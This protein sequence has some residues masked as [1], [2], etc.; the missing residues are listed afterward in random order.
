MT[1][2]PAESW[3]FTVIKSNLVVHT[4]PQLI[5]RNRRNI[6]IKNLALKHRDKITGVP[7]VNRGL[8]RSLWAARGLP[9]GRIGK[10]GR[11]WYKATLYASWGGS[12]ASL[13]ARTEL[14][15]PAHV[16]GHP[17]GP[18]PAALPAAPD[19]TTPLLESSEA[20]TLLCRVNKALW[21]LTAR[22][23]VRCRKYQSE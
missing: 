1:S 19:S 14:S 23:R 11:I 13:E 22:W 8:I 2:S 21:K 16:P 10:L 15:L 17:I 6:N 12:I 4:G 18:L 20:H 5:V 7:Y 3:Q 9:A